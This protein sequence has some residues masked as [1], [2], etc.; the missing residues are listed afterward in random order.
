[1]LK[2]SHE[3]ELVALGF[4]PEK[5]ALARRLRYLQTTL[6]LVSFLLTI[7]TALALGSVSKT[8][9]SSLLGVTGFRWFGVLTYAYVTLIITHWPL[10]LMAW[11]HGLGR[12]RLIPGLDRVPSL[13]QNLVRYFSVTLLAIPFF[14]LLY[15]FD[16]EPWY[17]TSWNPVPYLIFRIIFDLTFFN[18]QHL[19]LIKPDKVLRQRANELGKLLGIKPARIK[20][21]ILDSPRTTAAYVRVFLWERVVLSTELLRKLPSEELDVVLAHELAHQ[22]LSWLLSLVIG[23]RTMV[24]G[25]VVVL[26]LQRLAPLYGLERSEI[27]ALPI[28]IALA[29]L[30][31]FLAYP[32][33][34]AF[35]RWLERWADSRALQ[36]TD[37][38]E[39][40]SRAMI[41]LYDAGFTDAA[42]GR[43]WQFFFGSHPTGLE[44]VKRGRE[45]GLQKSQGGG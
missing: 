32:L 19:R 26:T 2:Y 23:I 22:K 3:A 35:R 10:P 18:F 33:E 37:D 16:S 36:I 9:L 29:E 31:I 34:N 13:T 42:P 41:T 20:L 21:W 1:M 24:P 30:G 27:A 15:S 39:A 28:F 5:R 12:R 38:P 7:C 17:R 11:A 8:F 6:C 45:L 40:F 14:A 44:R 43:L 4:D 25:V